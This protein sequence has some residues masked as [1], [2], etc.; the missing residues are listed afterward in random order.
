MLNSYF[1]NYEGFKELFIENGRRK[2]AIF[3]KSYLHA[4]KKGRREDFE[5]DFRV[6]NTN[7]LIPYMKKTVLRETRGINPIVICGFG[8]SSNIYSLDE[9]KGVCEDSDFNAV[10]YLKDGRTYK[11]KVGKFVRNILNEWNLIEKYGETLCNFYIE[12]VADK[13]K[14]ENSNIQ[15]TLKVDDDFEFI[16]SSSNAVNDYFGSC[17]TDEEQHSFYEKFVDASAAS[18]LNEEG[19]ILAR[20]V[21]F[22]NVYDST[23]N[24]TLRLAERQYSASSNTLFMQKLVS[25]LKKA[26]YIDGY[27]SIGC[28]AGDGRLFFLNDGTPIYDHKLSIKCTISRG[29]TLSYQDSFKYYCE[30][31]ETAYNHMPDGCYAS[32]DSTAPYFREDEED[33]NWDEYNEENT[34]D[35]VMTIGCWSAYYGR[36]NEMSCS[37]SYA[38]R[39][40]TYVEYLDMYVDETYYSDIMNEHLP[41]DNW[42]ELEEEYKENNWNYD[43][44]NEEYIEEDV[45]QCYI[46]DG[47]DSY[48]TMYVSEDYAESNFEMYD[49]YYYNELNDGV[50]YGIE[51]LQTV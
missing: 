29:D 35:E 46:Y 6:I 3:L 8:M 19:Q 24:T 20:C 40:F 17:M 39:N 1:N 42:E 38:E 45:I 41:L 15:A 11:M 5:K 33:T 28:R 16:Y 44:Y 4:C 25:M 14:E 2:N 31:K 32:L 18:I 27:K 7:A 30:E 12:A 34:Y 22:N 49:D 21:I 9:R 43:E 23:S 50:P 47:D 26:D 51:E 10:R 36:Y 48:N 13:W 37:E